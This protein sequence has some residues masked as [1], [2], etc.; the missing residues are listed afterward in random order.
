METIVVGEFG[1]KAGEKMVAL[2]KS[3]DCLR[4]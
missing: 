4:I 2:P 1:V 3:N